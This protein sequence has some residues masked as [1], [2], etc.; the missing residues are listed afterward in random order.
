M[1]IFAETAFGTQLNYNLFNI[2][3]NSHLNINIRVY[4]TW[5]ITVGWRVLLTFFRLIFSFSKMAKLFLGQLYMLLY[6]MV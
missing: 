1:E 4:F 5:W 3:T 2:Q 6:I